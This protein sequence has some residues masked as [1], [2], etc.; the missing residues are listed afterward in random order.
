MTEATALAE[1][2]TMRVGGVPEALIAPADTDALVRAARDLWDSGEE[3]LLLGGG[4]NTVASDDGFAGTVIHVVTRGIERIDAPSGRVRLRVQA[5][6]PWDEVVALTVRNGWS[7]V[8]ALSGIPGSTGAAPVQNIGA[9]GQELESAL[10]GVDFL[11]A[12]TGEVVRLSRSELELGYRT[13][14]LKRGRLGV[15]LAVELELSDN[16]VPGGVGAPLSA[17]V[18]YAQLADSL[19][20]PL[21]SRVP[22]AELRRAVLGLRASKGMVLDPDDPDS[23]SS[24]S[25]FTNPIVSES[26]ARSLPANAPRWPVTP[27]EPDVIIGLPAGG[28]HPLDIPPLADGPY[29]V[30]LSAAWLIENAGI[31]RGFALP[32]SGAGISSKHT[33]AIVNR[34]HA[35]ASDVAQ[36][37]SFIQSRV[38]AEFGVVLRP[39]PVLV[40]LTL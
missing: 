24:G 27:P 9:Y 15:V 34:G 32:G 33:L 16:T 17:P 40:G 10:V 13:S 37:A 26:F 35:S 29:D 1:L 5:G 2:T 25:F 31:R 18:A 4:S 39:E 23:V 21:G 30:K 20:V 8:E 14:A 12:A 38:Q 3:W 11:D 22:V 19:G 28:V 6:E 36:L 7:G